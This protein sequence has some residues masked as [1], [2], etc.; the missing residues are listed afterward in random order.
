M[1]S[2]NDYRLK[3]DSSNTHSIMVNCCLMLTRTTHPHP[4]IRRNVGAI[5]LHKNHKDGEEEFDSI[6][7]QEE[8][9]KLVNGSFL[10]NETLKSSRYGIETSI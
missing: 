10:S 3:A 9:V 2:E 1:L 8:K 6:H 7:E 5:R 4:L